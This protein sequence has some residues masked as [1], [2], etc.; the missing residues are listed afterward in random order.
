MF[1]FLVL[2]F[3]HMVVPCPNKTNQSINQYLSLFLFQLIMSLAYVQNSSRWVP[4]CQYPNPTWLVETTQGRKQKK[5]KK[6][7][8]TGLCRQDFYAVSQLFLRGP[9]GSRTVSGDPKSR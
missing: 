8:A 7:K 6:I 3:G 9:R 2:F 1:L 4:R 5:T